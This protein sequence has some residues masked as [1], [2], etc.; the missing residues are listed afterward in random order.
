LS[1]LILIRSQI[2]LVR[3]QPPQTRG[4]GGAQ[5]ASWADMLNYRENILRGRIGKPQ[6]SSDRF[7][8]R[9]SVFP[10]PAKVW[11]HRKTKHCTFRSTDIALRRNR[12]LDHKL[13]SQCPRTSVV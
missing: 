12:S 3:T 2:S 10:N 7:I 8:L 5:S 4:R 13:Y 6:L 11:S 9:F 1:C